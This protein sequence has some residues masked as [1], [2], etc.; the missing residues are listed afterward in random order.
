[1]EEFVSSPEGL[2][3]IAAFERIKS[4]DLR[5]EIVSFVKAIGSE[6]RWSRLDN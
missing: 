3:L 1:M 2:R 4:A 6:A 5:R